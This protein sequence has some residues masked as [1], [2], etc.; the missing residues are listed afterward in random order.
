MPTAPAV[1]FVLV[2]DHDILRVGVRELLETVPGY[3]VVGEAG[4]ARDGFRAIES[5][6]PD[7]VVMDVAL[8]GMDGIVATREVLRRAPRTRIVILSAYK[9]HHDV[10]NALSAGAMGYVLKADPPETLLRAVERSERSGPYLSPSLTAHLAALD[11]SSSRFDALRTLSE[12]ENEIFRLAADC[13]TSSEIARDLCVARKTVESH[14]NR[15]YRKLGLRSRAEL[16]RTA[17]G[18]GLVHSLRNAPRA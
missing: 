9:D 8:P 17:F 2:D 10:M 3:V 12:R 4:T 13:R 5:E 11:P 14:L 6:R 15:I 16:V 1:K 7:V 18:V